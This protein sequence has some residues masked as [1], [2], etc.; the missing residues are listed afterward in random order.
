[1]ERLWV[2]SKK[3][4]HPTK[5]EGTTPAERFSHV[6]LLLTLLMAMN[7]PSGHPTMD[8]HMVLSERINRVATSNTEDHVKEAALTLLVRDAEI[9]ASMNF[10]QAPKLAIFQDK[11]AEVNQHTEPLPI[12]D[13]NKSAILD[14]VDWHTEPLPIYHEKLLADQADNSG[15]QGQSFAV[16]GN[17]AKTDDR[18][19]YKLSSG[20]VDY[21]STVLKPR[22]R[23]KNSDGGYLFGTE[24]VIIPLLMH[25]ALIGIL[26]SVR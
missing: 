4:N 15:T 9:L 21:W 19:N 16:V 18:S 2:K 17:G 24:Y 26:K 10:T 1:M 14:N 11:A 23:T 5:L 25:I 22:P 7:H 6:S 3:T 13:E 12:Y 8:Q 20:G